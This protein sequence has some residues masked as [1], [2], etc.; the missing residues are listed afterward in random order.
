[1][2]TVYVIFQLDTE[3]F[4]TPETDNV[5][6]DLI[7][8][9]NRHGI[10][11]SFAIVGEKARVLERRRR[12]DVIKALKTQDIA[13]QSNYHSVHPTISEY[14]R[15]LGWEDGVKEVIRR[16]EGGIRD[17]K[18][19]FGQY[20][21]AF[22][23]PGGNWAPQ[24]PY[25][26]KKLGI[27]VYADGIFL[28]QPVWFCGIL[29]IRYSLSFN[30]REAGTE[31]HLQM[32]KEKFE[33]IYNSLKDKGGVIIIVLH[34]CMLLT[35]EFWDAINFAKGNMPK[36]LKTAPLIPEDLYKRKLARFEEFVDYITRHPNVKVITF[37]ELPSLY[38]E[39]NVELNIDE[40][41]ILA[42]KVLD[43]HSFHIINRKSISLADAFY[44]FSYALKEYK[45]KGVIPRKVRTYT[46]LGPVE[47]P[48]E[49]REHV[50]VRIGDV[51]NLA[52]EVYFNIVKSGVIPSAIK[53]NNKVIG[54]LSFL[55]A[56]AQTFLLLLKGE[57]TEKEL[58]I[59]STD[60]KPKFEG[61]D[62]V[63]RVCSQWRWIVFPKDFH[64]ERILELTILQ[65]WTLKPA[66]MKELKD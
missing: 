49:I 61:Y 43:K 10:K 25:A 21:S 42:K 62:L 52:K 36:E 44:V 23:Q 29:S 38:E 35:K 19:I 37:R 56:M 22:I 5:I 17:L 8:I 32:M 33:D 46:L 63:R 1:M 58:E 2:R 26:M 18:R 12:N 54:P 57:N 45:D 28:P 66:I 14:L 60:E 15:G 31:E 47:R 39:E 6:V 7:K 16:E 20:P 65:S 55:C 4:I 3:D 30:E 51:V 27:Q 13:Y 64:S 50:K 41:E 48:P 11:G 53:I 24:V 40:M 59:I 9:F 34:P